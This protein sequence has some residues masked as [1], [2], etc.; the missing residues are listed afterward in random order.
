MKEMTKEFFIENIETIEISE[1]YKIKD[2]G[3]VV[4][5]FSEYEKYLKLTN[6]QELE[7]LKQEIRKLDK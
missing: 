7:K 6:P 5:P 2:E 1:P 4:I 3:I